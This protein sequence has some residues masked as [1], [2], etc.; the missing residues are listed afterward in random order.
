MEVQNC[1]C[2][3]F[4][5]LKKEE[6]LFINLFIYGRMQNFKDFSMSLVPFENV[7]KDKLEPRFLN[8]LTDGEKNIQT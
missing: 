7:L 6:A 3:W 5:V 1:L 4:R 2:G 8:S